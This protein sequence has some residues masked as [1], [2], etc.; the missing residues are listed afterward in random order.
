VVGVEETEGK[1]LLERLLSSEVKG[2]LLTLFH[3]D[4]G[5][6]DSTE[7]LARRTGRTP[8]AIEEDLED[9]L[10]LGVLKRKRVDGLDMV[11]LD[12]ARDN[13]IQRIIANELKSHESDL[14]AEA[15]L[16]P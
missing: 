16:R 13:E 14:A 2:D 6:V 9:L 12:R 5:L 1:R 8:K 10:D 3:E 7:G 15:V 11:V 4:P